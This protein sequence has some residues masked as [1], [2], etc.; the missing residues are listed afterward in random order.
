MVGQKKIA[1][2]YY[3]LAGK[4]RIDGLLYVKHAD[5]L[6]LYWMEVDKTHKSRKSTAYLVA[7]PRIG[8]AIENEFA[9]YD[10]PKGYE[11]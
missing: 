9:I 6:S 2:K 1:P 3:L 5:T 4:N 10:F 7:G 11:N 8:R